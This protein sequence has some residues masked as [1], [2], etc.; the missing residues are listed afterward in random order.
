MT[1]LRL[2][3]IDTTRLEDGRYAVLLGN[4]IPIKGVGDGCILTALIRE[5]NIKYPT[6]PIVLRTKGP[7]DVFLNNP[8]IYKMEDNLINHSVDLGAGHYITRK[9]RYFGIENPELKGELFFTPKELNIARETIKLLSG[10]KP[11]VIFCQN[12]TDNRRNWTREAWEAAIDIMSPQFDFYQVEQKIHYHRF[13]PDDP[14]DSLPCLYDTVRNARQELRNGELRKIMALQ[15]VTKR[16]LTSNTGFY[17]I[18]MSVGDVACFLHTKYAGGDGEW[19]Y[20]QAY[21][22]FEDSDPTVVSN[23]I[24]E[25]WAV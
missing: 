12:S 11:V 9:C 10:T 22:F 21:N 2:P 6:I 1:D 15:A 14:C 25:R 4:H 3:E 18:G 17:H 16:T 5:F 19:T 8:R 7:K 23:T 13:E 24:L 20:P